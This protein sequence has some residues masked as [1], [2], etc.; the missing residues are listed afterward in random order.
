MTDQSMAYDQQQLK[1]AGDGS[2]TAVGDMRTHLANHDAQVSALGNWCN[3]NNDPNDLIAGLLEGMV[4]AF[5]QIK[6]E[7]GNQNL[8]AH[9]Q[10]V[11]AIHA[12]RT[13]IAGAE[14]ANTGL[15]QQV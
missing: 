4:G 15:V 9:E 12:T 3:P 1:Q 7:T 13:N 14:N 11:T 2:A 10:N 5:R 6:T 8:D